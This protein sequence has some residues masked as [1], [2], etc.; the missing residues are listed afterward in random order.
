MTIKVNL[1]G[2]NKLVDSTRKEFNK[3]SNEA[4]DF[5]IK[6][7]PI[8]SGNARRNTSL[9]NNKSIQ[10][11]YPYAQ[12]LDQGW[13]KQSPEGM[14]APTIEHIQTVLIPKAVRRINS[15]K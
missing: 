15:G 12:R 14:T 2:F 5:F 13:S 9:V 7:T 1:Q 10:A 3:V 4:Y 11:V 6:E 8:R